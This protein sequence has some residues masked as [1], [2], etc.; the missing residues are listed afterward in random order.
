MM[1]QHRCRS[2]CACIALALCLW[3]GAARAQNADALEPEPATERVGSL[4]EAKQILDA[5][6]PS[7]QLQA[8]ALSRAH[9]DLDRALSQLLPRLELNADY[10]LYQRVIGPD[11]TLQL[12]SRSFTPNVGAAL[13]ITFSLGRLAAVSSTAL[14]R[15]ARELNVAATRHQL[16]GALAA[17]ILAVLSAERVAVRTRSG[18][19]AAEE[20]MR[21]TSRLAE[22][23]SITAISALRFSQDLSD[24][25]SELVTAVETLSQARRTLGQAL[26]LSAS[27]GVAEEL[28]PEALL[29]QLE[30]G[31]RPIRD[32]TA[33][34]DRR[35][36]EKQLESTAA[37]ISA[38]K[39]AYLPEARLTTQYIAR[40]TPS[41][42]TANERDLVNDLIARAS[43]VWTIYDGG[44]RSAEITR[45]EADRQAQQAE[46]ERVVIESEQEYRRSARLTAVTTATLQA[47]QTSVAAAREIDRLSRKAL[48]LG[49]ATALEVVDNAR[50]LRSLEVTLAIR[51]VE[52]VAARARQRISSS[53]CE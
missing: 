25:K 36:A 13:S 34:L 19:V 10:V 12:D 9:A 37:A 27:V 11:S 44:Q 51:E 31:C 5:R 20:R 18:Y 16:I 3:A 21:I 17:A 32:L 39:L 50:R 7:L 1:T 4:S 41:L 24:A 23:G 46:Q 49:T 35:A 22:L 15:D 53:I 42:D 43:L 29:S 33:R 47:A 8:S 52:Q 6:Q 2:V 28:Q 14:Q 30:S 48:E 45:A 40:L 26:G 38:A